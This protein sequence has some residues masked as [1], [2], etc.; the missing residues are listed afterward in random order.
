M[1]EKATLRAARS[2]SALVSTIT[3]FLP[4]SSR[5]TGVRLAAASRATDLPTTGDPV[6]KRWS[7]GSTEK[8]EPRPCSGPITVSSSTAK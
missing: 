4:P 3:G 1:R 2:T 5:V 8:S 6:K 7:N